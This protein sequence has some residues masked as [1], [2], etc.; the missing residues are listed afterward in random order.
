MDDFFTRYREKFA[1]NFLRALGEERPSVLSTQ[2]LNTLVKKLY[3]LLFMSSQ[4]DELFNLSYALAKYGVDLRK[5]LI[6]TCLTLVRDYIDQLLAEEG[7][8]GK[9][10]LLL[11]LVEERLSTV[12][13]A[14]TKYVKEELEK[15]RKKEKGDDA[16]ALDLLKGLLSKSDTDI[17]LL[18]YYKEV[19][20]VCRSRILSVGKG[21]LRVKACNLNL[22]KLGNDLFIKHP[23]LPRPIAVKIKDVDVKREELELEV[24]GL[25][26]FPKERRRYLRVVP[27]ETMTVSVRKDDWEGLGTVADI[28]VGGI[29]VYLKDKDDLT[30]EDEVIVKFQLP[31]GTIETEASVRY[32]IPYGDVYRVGLRYEL[33]LKKEDIVSDWV[34]ERQ[35]EILR[36]IKSL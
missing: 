12:E 20:V 24:L 4:T 34:M 18:T 11:K 32:V 1:E 21:S 19:P 14:Y 29:G 17:E 25:R 8:Y 27:K 7:D 15:R 22:L 35:F 6:K 13:D 2:G 3:V 31:K 10:R 36:E 5:V 16:L 33:D 28:S 23:S 26:D 30:T 9:V